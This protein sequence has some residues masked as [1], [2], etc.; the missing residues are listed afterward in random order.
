[1]DVLGK[2]VSIVMCTYNGERHL[3]EQLDSVLNQTY[4]LHE[5]IIQ[6]DG[7]TDGTMAIVEEYAA[8]NSIIKPCVN[9]G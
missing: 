5:I 3:R 2:R 4:G 6:D 9:K 8:R 1:M 7:S